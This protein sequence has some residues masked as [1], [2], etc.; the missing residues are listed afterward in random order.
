MKSINKRFWIFE[1]GVILYSL[2]ILLIADAMFG[3]SEIE[4]K[5]IF[6]GIFLICGLITWLV[7]EGKHWLLFALIYEV[8]LLSILLMIFWIV[9]FCETP[10]ELWFVKD[11]YTEDFEW[12]LAIIIIIGIIT[13]IPTLALSFF[14][15]N[16]FRYILPDKKIH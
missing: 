11:T 12:L 7:M 10:P 9:F 8:I 5:L 13:I 16:I 15:Y 6:T 14:G 1:A 3:Y 4:F 2:F